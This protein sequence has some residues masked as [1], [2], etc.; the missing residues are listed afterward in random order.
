MI[1]E[2]SSK[3]VSS[4]ESTPVLE[5]SRSTSPVLSEDRLLLYQLA[6]KEKQLD[7]EMSSGRDSSYH[8]SRMSR[9]DSFQS[10]E[11]KASP[12]DFVTPK[13]RKQP[14]EFVYESPHRRTGCSSGSV[15]PRRKL[16]YRRQS[17]SGSSSSRTT[18]R[19]L[20]RRRRFMSKSP[21]EYDSD[22][23]QQ[24]S[25]EELERK[26]SVAPTRSVNVL[27]V[28]APAAAGSADSLPV[29]EYEEE[30]WVPGVS[31]F[32]TSLIRKVID[33]NGYESD[34][35]VT[36]VPML[37]SD[38]G[39]FKPSIFW[40]PPNPY[41]A[42]RMEQLRQQVI[43]STASAPNIKSFSKPPP[44]LERVAEV[45]DSIEQITVK[46][47]T[48]IRVMREM[49]KPP[50]DWNDILSDHNDKRLP[51]SS[52]IRLLPTQAKQ[53]ELSLIWALNDTNYIDHFQQYTKSVLQDQSTMV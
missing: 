53:L 39:R 40:L 2:P 10:S 24:F 34:P 13:I 12:S 23:C 37:K 1:T 18:R 52:K 36:E 17:S 19:F 38:E 35:I 46:E 14:D 22:T 47:A 41:I 9:K 44:T 31:H 25:D 27:V 29:D 5:K 42:A 51:H 16:C 30:S 49:P 6:Q 26:C 7:E 21:V 11:A 4:R 32:F 8:Q 43:T 3:D 50:E 28:N 20:K 48:K 15:S 33:L 45:G